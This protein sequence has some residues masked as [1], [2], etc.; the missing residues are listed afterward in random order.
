MLL[1][2]GNE[3]KIRNKEYK[4]KKQ[5]KY[6]DIKRDLAISATLNCFLGDKNATFKRKES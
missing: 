4:T 3:K 6:T 5:I 2:K 1:I